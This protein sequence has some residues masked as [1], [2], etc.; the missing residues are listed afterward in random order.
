MKK[1]FWFLVATLVGLVI[2]SGGVCTAD[3]S[4]GQLAKISTQSNSLA[5]V[6]LRSS[7]ALTNGQSPPPTNGSAYSVFSSPMQYS[8]GAPPPDP[9][10]TNWVYTRNT[11]FWLN[12][13]QGLDALN[14]FPYQMQLTLVT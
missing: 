2:G 3:S 1:R 11:N 13:V 12:G 6:I 4:V 5:A 10:W 14:V 8:F 7:L 9:G